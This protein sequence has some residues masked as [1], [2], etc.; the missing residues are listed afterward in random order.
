MIIFRTDGN[1]TIGSGHVMRCLSIANAIASRNEKCLFVLADSSFE[2]IINELGYDSVVLNSDYSDMNNE[3]E[4]FSEIINNIQPWLV[5]IDSYYVTKEYL[6]SLKNIAYTVY[7]D[8]LASFAYPV[9]CL[10]NYNIYGKD[11][12]YK[13]LYK[14]T[15]CLP[16]MLLGIEYI[17]VRAMFKNVEKRVQKQIVDDVLISTGGADP[18]HLA[19]EITRYIRSI[20]DTKRYHILVGAMNPDYEEI[21]QIASAC[22]NVIVHHNVKN[23][24]S[25]IMS[26]DIA[27]SASGSTLY[28]LCA[29]G[30]PMII[31]T[32][33]DN[34]IL[35]NKKFIDL[36]LAKSCGDL[37]YSDNPVKTIFDGVS[38]LCDN[39]QIRCSVG[40]KM[41]S[42]VDG[43]GADR[44]ADA[45][46]RFSR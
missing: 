4:Q 16:D 20:N 3:L 40:A 27:V 14:G 36:G 7:I 19:L 43:N 38:D 13:G 24:R 17:P 12:D 1:E 15:G 39:Y 2:G 30:V 33:A 22:E 21:L 31:Y 46:L 32:L 9:N 10:I 23:M 29:C 26:C 5:I 44:I 34:Q 11:L 35:G 18:I 41:Q 42:V 37:R 25:L 8:D 45:L 28:E 6:A